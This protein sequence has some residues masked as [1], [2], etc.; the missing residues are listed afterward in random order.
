MLHSSISNSNQRI[1]EGPA[2]K[3]AVTTLIFL[4]LMLVYFENNFRSQGHYKN[5][6]DS[7]ALWASFRDDVH[8]KNGIK[9]IVLLGT[10]RMVMD[11]DLDVMQK[12]FPDHKIIQLAI[13][14][15]SAYNILQDLSQDPTFDGLLICDTL[16][17]FLLPNLSD[18]EYL[19]Y[20]R[21]NYHALS[22]DNIDTQARGFLQD[23]LVLSRSELKLYSLL[24]A[25]FSVE[26]HFYS[27]K[28][29][30]Q[31]LA[32]FQKTM[33]PEALK[34]MLVGSLAKRKRSISK[35]K[36]LSVEDYKNKVTP[37]LKGVQEN[38][39]KH[40]AKFLLLSLPTSD[41]I[42]QVEETLY[43]KKEYWD[44]LSEWSAVSTLHLRDHSELFEDL[45]FPDGS[46][47]DASEVTVFTQR[48]LPLI[49]DKL[50]IKNK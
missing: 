49:K 13:N 16:P 3:M 7:I 41:G 50:R 43:P 35:M 39:N 36:I 25:G 8:T 34:E 46:H 40:G 28:H 27:M 12:E 2:I 11:I 44:K 15:R 23:R 45:S 42:W 30:R 4:L 32:H 18:L 14:G 20:Y 21:E 5:V 37:Y 22:A 19:K 10:S 47:L 24:Y 17:E 26:P 48:L 33:S 1:P 38:L 31:G 6:R 29:N 9:R